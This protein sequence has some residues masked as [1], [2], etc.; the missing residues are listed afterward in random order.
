MKTTSKVIFTRDKKKF[1]YGKEWSANESIER[2]NRPN[3][4]YLS[5]AAQWNIKLAEEIIEW[6]LNVNALHGLSFTKYAGVSIDLLQSKKMRKKLV[7]LMRKA[8]LGIEGM[9]VKKLSL[10]HI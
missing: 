10:I 4:L 7:E 3:A 5:V 2:F 6:F 9:K 1:D 8:D